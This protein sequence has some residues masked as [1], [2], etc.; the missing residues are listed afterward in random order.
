MLRHIAVALVN[1]LVYA[2]QFVDLGRPARPGT[3]IDPIRS[4]C[5]VGG[6]DFDL[7]IAP[8][9]ICKVVAV[10]AGD[11]ACVGR[12]NLISMATAAGNDK[13]DVERFAAEANRARVMLDG[14][15]MA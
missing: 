8:T 5:Q 4:N 3:P 11:F 13:G 14:V 12:H 2:F 9:F 10:I 1:G 6:S 15:S 7:G